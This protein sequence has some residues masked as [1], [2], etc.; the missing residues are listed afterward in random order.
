VDFSVERGGKAMKGM[1]RSGRGEDLAG[2]KI[3]V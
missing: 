2:A 1:A 3:K